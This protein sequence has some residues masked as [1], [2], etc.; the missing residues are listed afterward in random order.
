MSSRSETN[1]AGANDA[2]SG[3][4]CGFLKYSVCVMEQLFEES[5]HLLLCKPLILQVSGSRLLPES[6]AGF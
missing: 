6:F 4:S 1:Q 3:I 2:V 5:G